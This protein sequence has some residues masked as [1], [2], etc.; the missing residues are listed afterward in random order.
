M[1]AKSAIPTVHFYG[2]EA[3]IDTGINSLDVLHCEALITRSQEHQ[4][5]IKPHRHH[6]LVQLF[7]LKKGAVEA[8]FDG[9]TIQAQAPSLLI[10][11]AMCVH[12]FQW[13]HEVEGTVLSLSSAILEPLSQELKKEKLSLD[14]ARAIA[15]EENTQQLEQLLQLLMLEYQ[16]PGEDS[17]SQALFSLIKL[18]IIWLERNAGKQTEKGGSN[19]RQ[20]QYFNQ[21]NQQ[22]N[23]DFAKHRSV[24]SYAEELGITSHYLNKLCQ[25]L[26]QKKALQLVHERLLLEAKRNLVYS[27]QSISEI[28]YQ[29]GFNDPAYFTRFFKRL[30]GQS[31]K[32][33]KNQKEV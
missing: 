24:E 19:H 15:L 28:A 23:R 18:L 30:T 4:F 33:F 10:V 13:T 1:T 17:R 11:P 8:T 7:Y 6:E 9:Q 31:P 25:Q 22:I 2:E 16:N 27:A 29:L 3:D 21:F 14:S 20:T 26:V 5:K 12:D 32:A